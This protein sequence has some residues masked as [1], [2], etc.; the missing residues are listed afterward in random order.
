MIGQGDLFQ[1][2]GAVRMWEPF[3]A[4]DGCWRVLVLD[5]CGDRRLLSAAS[6]G[7]GRSMAAAVR[8]GR[9]LALMAAVA[10]GAVGGPEALPAERRTLALD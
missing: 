7:D 8:S 2:G 10:P 5:D 9:E 6:E 1:R 4:S 3:R